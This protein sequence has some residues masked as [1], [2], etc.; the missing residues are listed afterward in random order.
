MTPA[1][2][3]EALRGLA[4]RAATAVLLADSIEQGT[5]QVSQIPLELREQ[6][7]RAQDKAVASRFESLFG[8]VSSD[9]QEVIERYSLGLNANTTA[10]DYAA[11]EQVFRQVCAQCHRLSDLGNDVGPP[12]KQL[13][14]KS[15]QQLLETILDPNREI[16]PKYM[17]YTV[18]DADDRVLTGI[19]QDETSGQIVLK[20]PGGEVH[21]LARQ[22]ISELKSSG[23]S[24]MPVGLEAS[25]SVEQMRQL[26]QFLKAAKP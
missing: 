8:K 24:L 7:R 6:L 16:D 21:T 11:G 5:V 10:E 25:I 17:S 18:L 20:S 4:G 23:V 19:I 3:T 15:P 12:L 22:A 13:A 1:L 9:R 26:I 2:Q 14:D